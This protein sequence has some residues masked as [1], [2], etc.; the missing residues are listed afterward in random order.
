MN[1]SAGNPPAGRADCRKCVHFRGAPYEAKFEGCYLEKNMASKQKQACL[2]EQ[3]LPGDHTKI[4]A[5]GNCP[6]F[7]ARKVKPS[8]WQRLWAVSA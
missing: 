2:D 6:D 7:L 5:D 4:N 1:H 3:Q 8:L